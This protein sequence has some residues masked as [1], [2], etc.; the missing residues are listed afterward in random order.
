MVD[1][2]AGM[3]AGHDVMGVIRR[4]RKVRDV[5][6][7]ACIL[8]AAWPRSFGHTDIG[9]RCLLPLRTNREPQGDS[10]VIRSG[11]YR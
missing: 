4:H 9:F 7:A 11:E 6:T 5:M 1:L 10:V 8:I 2:L 3:T